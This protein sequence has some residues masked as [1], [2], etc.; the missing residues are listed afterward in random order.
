MS[1]ANAS[2]AAAQRDDSASVATIVEALEAYAEDHGTY[3]VA[4]SGWKGNGSGW[5]GLANGSNYPESIAV[6]LI[7]GGYLP[8]G[9]QWRNTGRRFMVYRCDDSAAVFAQS[10][11]TV[12]RVDNIDWRGCTQAPINRYNRGYYEVTAPLDSAVRADTARQVANALEAYAAD[13]E[14]YRVSGTGWKGNGTGWFGYSG[15]Q[16]PQSVASV[17]VDRGYLPSGNW[18]ESM[19]QFDLMVYVC[20]NGRAAVFADSEVAPAAADRAAWSRCTTSPVQNYGRRYY[21]VTDTVANVSGPHRVKLGEPGCDPVPKPNKATLVFTITNETATAQSYELNVGPQGHRSFVVQASS[22]EKFTLRGIPYGTHDVTVLVDGDVV[23]TDNGMRFASCEQDLFES[24][25][26]SI[27]FLPGDG[28][29]VEY[30][31]G[32]DR[33]QLAASL[34]TAEDTMIETMRA[35]SEG[36]LDIGRV[37]AL[38]YNE[39]PPQSDRRAGGP[40]SGLR[41]D[42]AAILNETIAD[43]T[44]DLCTYLASTGVDT[45][46]IWTNHLTPADVANGVDADAEVEPTESAMSFPHNDLNLANHANDPAWLPKCGHTYVVYNLNITRLEGSPIHVVMHQIENMLG[47]GPTRSQ[48]YNLADNRLVGR[49]SIDKR[50]FDWVGYEGAPPHEYS[51]HRPGGW[52]HVDGT[53]SS[54]RDHHHH[55]YVHLNRNAWATECGDSHW[56]TNIHRHPD[57]SHNFDEYRFHAPNNRQSSCED[58]NPQGTG[59]RVNVTCATWDGCLDGGR[60]VDEAVANYQRWWLQQLPGT[61]LSRQLYYDHSDGQRYPLR[62]FWQV[63]ADFDSVAGEPTFDGTFTSVDSYMIDFESPMS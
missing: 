4:G 36:Q 59:N 6:R 41:P 32:K 27:R 13:H 63:Y 60:T 1:L 51:Y 7:E 46:V 57:H 9:P 42:Y 24:R 17:L 28:D 20:S 49:K 58:W 8:D 39:R 18:E 34:E 10:T 62:N 25:I 5:F 55:H 54:T 22:T 16:Y 29:N 47:Y 61:D 23:A 12:D 52:R 14:T 21:V 30:T 48:T 40:D 3:R 44:G 37:Q 38:T 56:A 50:L 19:H 26:L 15:G 43:D 45:I 31:G 2:P 35:S 53:F 33:V 11:A